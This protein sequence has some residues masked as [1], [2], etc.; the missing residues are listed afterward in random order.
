MELMKGMKEAKWPVVGYF[1]TG[2]H[3]GSVIGD[4]GD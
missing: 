4:S 3:S 1:R 2:L